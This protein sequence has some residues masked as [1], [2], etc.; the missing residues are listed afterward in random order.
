MTTIMAHRG[1]RNLWAENSLQGFRNVLELGV[2]AVEF[3]RHLGAGG[4]VLVIHDAT[5]ERTTTGSGPVRLLNETTRHDLRLIDPQGEVDEG[6]PL[7]SEVLEILAPVP[8]LRLLPEFKGDENGHYDPALIPAAV[9]IFRAYG[10]ESRTT[11]HSFEADVLFAIAQTAPEFDRMIS[12]NQDWADRQG[13]IEAF[14]TRYR[15]LV[16]CF[17]VHHDLFA[18]E[19]ERIT[20]MVPL[21]RLGVWTLNDPDLIAHWLDRGPGYLT[22][23]NPRLAQSIQTQRAVA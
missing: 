8:G 5:L 21:E 15:D 6:V 19:F 2:E 17:G 4:E 7:L 11:L 18:A 20:A 1:A 22:T 13:G 3:D 16:S 23:D 12:V 14:L 10:L 9:D